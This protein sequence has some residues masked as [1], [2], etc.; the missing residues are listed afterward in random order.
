MNEG[1]Y[2]TSR[3]DSIGMPGIEFA[4]LMTAVLG[5]NVLFRFRATGSSMTPFI[6]D[7]DLI[8]IEPASE[9]LRPGD[10]AVFVNFR[11]NQLMVHRILHASPSGYVIRG[12]NNSEPDGLMT[13]SSIIG[14]VVR[15]ER[16]GR[17]VRLGL[18]I[19]GV[20][21]AW[22]SRYGWLSPMVS[23]T[24]SILKGRPIHRQ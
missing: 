17:R 6:L 19:E 2:V 3:P 7:G 4:G 13:A 18:G 15:V 14:R 12:D 23:M 20:V 22:L 9:R 5:K 1:A 24:R 10:V 8:T 16:R 11:C 21:I